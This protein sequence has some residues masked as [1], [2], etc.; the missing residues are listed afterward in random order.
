MAERDERDGGLARV[1]TAP[2]RAVTRILLPGDPAGDPKPGVPARSAIVDCGLYVDGVRQPGTPGYGDALAA[3]DGFVWLALR[4]PTAAEMSGV[5]EAFGL[6]DLAVADA[7]QPGQRPK[8]SELSA[9]VSELALRTAR[10]VDRG[11]P[12]DTTDVV[13]TGDLVIFVGP[14]F[15]ISVAHGDAHRLVPVPADLE[16]RRKLLRLGPWAI[17]YAATDRVIGRYL[18][19]AERVEDDLDELETSAF[20]RHARGGFQRIYQLERELVEFRRCAVPLQRPL[21]ALAGEDSEAPPELRRYFRDARDHLTRTVEQLSTF[22][23][24]LE[25]IL[26]ARLAQVTVDQN[27]DLRKIAAWAAIATSQTLIAGIYGM[28]FTF[29]PELSSTYGYPIVLTLMGLSALTL[30]R[31]F[32]RSG[33]L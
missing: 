1:W 15:V 28:R 30:F 29:M 6:P 26:A 4:E 32:R 23:D 31:F 33:W 22:D 3:K 19:V 11:V 13:H 21:A 27:N 14:R 8:L 20:S 2:V 25:S 9:E 18:Q 10:Y 5:A 12:H 24:L 7:L 17:A 16:T